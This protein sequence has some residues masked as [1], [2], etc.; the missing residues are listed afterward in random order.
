MGLC[1]LKLDERRLW[2]LSSGRS[3]RTAND[4]TKDDEQQRGREVGKK[5]SG[6]WLLGAG[7]HRLGG[8]RVVTA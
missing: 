1:G 8:G 2:L 5:D 3:R 7:K 6:F 4:G